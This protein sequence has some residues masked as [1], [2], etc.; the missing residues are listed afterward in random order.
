MCEGEKHCMACH[1]FGCTGWRKKFRIEIGEVSTIDLF[2]VTS[3][4]K[5]WFEIL[6]ENQNSSFYG[7]TTV[8]VIG[9]EDG[10]D[11]V[12]LATLWFAKEYGGV[13]AKTQNGFGQ[14][15]LEN[16]TFEDVKEG[17]KK[18]KETAEEAQNVGNALL[19]SISD[20]FVLKFK[21]DEH[22]PTVQYYL[23]KPFFTPFNKNQISQWRNFLKN[24]F[25]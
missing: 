19:P 20:F 4:N 5:R 17:F 18:I 15:D 14:I 8:K 2:L 25:I 16:L 7:E 22:D 9:F 24:N 21:V 3:S 11:N 23:N 1:V 12:V 13:G 10:I 6:Y